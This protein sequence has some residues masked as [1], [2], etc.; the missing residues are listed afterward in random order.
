MYN[1]VNETQGA[2]L[3]ATVFQKPLCAHSFL[4]MLAKGKMG[5]VV[6]IQRPAGKVIKSL[7]S[8]QAELC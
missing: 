3:S 7:L 8:I 4:P 2:R 6:S 5:V 1:T